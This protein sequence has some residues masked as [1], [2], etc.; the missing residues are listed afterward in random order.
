MGDD[1]KSLSGLYNADLDYI[2][3]KYVRAEEER[4]RREQQEAL[5]KKAEEEEN[6]RKAAIA[7]AQAEEERRRRQEEEARL[8]QLA[9]ARKAREE[10]ERKRKERE[11]AFQKELDAI[12]DETS[13]LETSIN[14]LNRKRIDLNRDLKDEENEIRVPLDEVIQQ[15]MELGHTESK[16]RRELKAFEDRANKMKGDLN[17][18]EQD[19]HQRKKLL[20]GK[21]RQ[22]QTD[23]LRAISS[24]GST[25]NLGTPANESVSYPSSEL[26]SRI[27]IIK[28]TTSENYVAPVPF[29][30][31]TPETGTS[32][33]R[34][35]GDTL[36][37][38]IQLLDDFLRTGVLTQA[39]YDD[40]KA[41]AYKAERE[42]RGN[43]SIQPQPIPRVNTAPARQP[44]PVQIPKTGADAQIAQL[45]DFLR[46]GVLNQAEYEDA[47]QKVLQDFGIAQVQVTVPPG[48]S[49][50]SQMTVEHKGQLYNVVVPNGVAPF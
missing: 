12:E 29:I 1:R 43:A 10:E 27:D 17:K 13:R 2:D 26:S 34:G 7:L 49:S 22:I 19:L 28:D 14:E 3:E 24:Y 25:T 45:D 16:L 15:R 36:E 48:V 23:M 20:A 8:A 39:E 46:Q 40:A 50:G 21:R 47:K 9:A 42:K 11:A 18:T 35:G 41:K 33:G 38:Q 32:S 30:E 31:K 5:R 44:T 37:D 4:K 6:R